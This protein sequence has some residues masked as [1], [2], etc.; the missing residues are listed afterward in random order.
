MTTASALALGDLSCPMRRTRRRIPRGY[1]L[2]SLPLG[3]PAPTPRLPPGFPTSPP[4]RRPHPTQPVAHRIA[5]L[6]PLRSPPPRLAPS[7]LLID[8]ARHAIPNESSPMGSWHSRSRSTSPFA[9]EASLGIGCAFKQGSSNK[10][11]ALILRVEKSS[12]SGSLTRVGRSWP[13]A[14]QLISREALPGQA[15]GL[16]R[17]VREWTRGSRPHP[18]PPWRQSTLAP[19]DATRQCSASAPCSFPPDESCPCP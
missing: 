6:R 7:H 16:A 9:R 2:S 19:R 18:A 14:W 17:P 8:T 13:P 5:Q 15:A 3:A 12:R 10:A 1:W 4:G 11:G